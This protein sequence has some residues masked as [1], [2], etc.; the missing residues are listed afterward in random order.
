MSKLENTVQLIGNLGADPEI[1]NLDGGK[2]VA[3]FSIAT[4]ERYKNKAGEMITDTQWHLVEAWGRTAEVIGQYVEK[5]NRIGI[6]GKLKNNRY[7]DKD[8]VNRIVSYVQCTE[9]MMM[10]K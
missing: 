4:N 9:L 6:Q 2:T 1:K 10:G 5:G 3:K 8:G 7:T